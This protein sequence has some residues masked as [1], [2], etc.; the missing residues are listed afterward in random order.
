LGLIYSNVESTFRDHRESTSTQERLAITARA[1]FPVGN[2]LQLSDDGIGI[3]CP[4]FAGMAMRLFGPYL[5]SLIYGFLV[6]VGLSVAAFLVRYQDGRVF[7]VPLI[8]FALTLMLL[9][10]LAT[11]K[12]NLD[13]T[14]IGGIRY[15][16]IAGILPALHI[17]FEI[18]ERAERRPPV[19]GIRLILLGSQVFVLVVTIFVRNAA[20][21]L[22]GP[23]IVGAVLALYAIRADRARLS[24]V[25]RKI[26]VTAAAFMLFSSLMIVSVPSSYLKAGKAFGI[27][28]HRAVVGY[29]VNP[30]WPFPGVRQTYRCARAIPEG[31]VPGIIDR[32]GH[33]IWFAYG[34]NHDRSIAQ[35]NREIYGRR[36]EA[37]MR[38]AFFHI[39]RLDPHD[40]LETFFYYKPQAIVRA[41]LGAF[42]F[43]VS[44][45][46]HA[47]AMIVLLQL[48]ITTLSFA[49]SVSDSPFHTL[50]TLA[51]PLLLFFLCSLP[52]QIVA[53][54]RLWD[55]P[56]MILYEFCVSLLV[57]GLALEHGAK[58]L[59]QRAMHPAS[60]RIGDMS[61]ISKSKGAR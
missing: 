33:C 22:L 26:T 45:F 14:P 40:A 19:N 25:I 6:M 59:A 27:I 2:S 61:A 4:V 39:M 1:T 41:A 37:V 36:Y 51:G 21:Y 34:P 42:S 30:G 60:T 52:S 55:V 24:A 49:I 47:I 28:W 3:G 31:I 16:V 50:R 13:Q 23:L 7:M 32:D 12:A 18:T 56:D 38:D 43:H 29:G 46:D 15:F 5:S 8:F 9:T 54:S 10:P 20:G 53:W 58:R 11:S 48:V 57:L 17:Y 35:L 44:G